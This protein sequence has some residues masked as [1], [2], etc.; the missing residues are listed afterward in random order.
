MCARLRRSELSEINKGRPPGGSPPAEAHGGQPQI[1]LSS[2]A[3]MTVAADVPF[4]RPRGPAAT[5]AVGIATA[6]A[7]ATAPAIT[8]PAGPVAASPGSA[9]SPADSNSGSTVYATPDSARSAAVVMQPY[10][11]AAKVEPG[12]ED[13]DVDEHAGLSPGAS[14]SGSG[15]SRSPT[16]DTG[17]MSNTSTTESGEPDRKKQRRNKP[18]LSCLECVE[19]KTKVSRQYPRRVFWC[20]V[21]GS[22]VPAA[23]SSRSVS[24]ATPSLQLFGA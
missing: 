8:A 12:E 21:F 15:N 5:A 19:R 24:V 18:T 14:G 4:Y 22:G 6:T 10:I 17:R 2:A 11:V 9:V 20:L 13:E 7:A 16:A 1:V 3:Q 23:P